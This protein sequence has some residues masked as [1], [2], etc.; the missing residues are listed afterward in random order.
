MFEQLQEER[1]DLY[2][3]CYMYEMALKLEESKKCTKVESW[4]VLSQVLSDKE[5]ILYVT[6]FEVDFDIITATISG[7]YTQES[8]LE[9]C[10]NAK[11]LRV[12]S[13]IDKKRIKIVFKIANY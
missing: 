3:S 7:C 4:R 9:K 1:E 5:G 10:K 6:E 11:S 8:T 13:G 2:L 12:A